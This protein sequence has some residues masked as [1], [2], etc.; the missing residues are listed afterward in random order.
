MFPYSPGVLD[1]QN[2]A[3]LEEASQQTGCF[4]F[5]RSRKERIR[6]YTVHE[7]KCIEGYC[8]TASARQHVDENRAQWVDKTESAI[9][10]LTPDFLLLCAAMEDHALRAR[11]E[12][13]FFHVRNSAQFEISSW[14]PAHLRDLSGSMIRHRGPLNPEGF[15]RYPDT[16][17][18][19]RRRSYSRVVQPATIHELFD[20]PK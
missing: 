14:P 2:I 18:S 13:F 12:R 6:T 17:S 7:G 10:Y 3:A 1:S 4:R 19:L 11:R 16:G 9:V 5:R 8:S 20:Q 15:L